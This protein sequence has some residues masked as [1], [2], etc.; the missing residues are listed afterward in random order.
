MESL[1][2]AIRSSRDR[3][4]GFSRLVRRSLDPFFF[5][6]RKK[7]KENVDVASVCPCDVFDFMHL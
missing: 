6:E 7:K 3:V 5:S 2:S 4:F 1:E